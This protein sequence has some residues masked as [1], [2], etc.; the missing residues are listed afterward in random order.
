MLRVVVLSLSLLS[1]VAA[2]DYEG[3]QVLRMTLLSEEQEEA[4]LPLLEDEELDFWKFPTDLMVPP[5]RVK[6]IKEYLYASKIPHNIW[7]ADVQSRID[8]QF[9]GKPR[10]DEFDYSVYHTVDEIYEWVDSMVATYPTLASSESIGMSYEDNDLVVLKMGVNTGK[11]KRNVWFKSLLH[12]REWVSGAACM[13]IANRLMSEYSSNE[14]IQ[15][16]LETYDF[17]YMPVVN[18]DGYNAS[19]H[20][21]RLWRKTRSALNGSSCI[22]VDGNRN[23]DFNWGQSGASPLPCT[24]T[25][26]GPE[27]LSEPETA[28]V[29]EFFRSR[30]DIVFDIFLDYHSYSQM[31]LSPWGY[32]D[33][34]PS[35]FAAMDEAMK[36]STEAIAAVH[37]MTY[38]YGASGP[39]LYTTSGTTVDWAYGDQ[40]IVHSYTYELRDEGQYGF[41]LP[42]DQIIPTAE[43]NY[44]GFVALCMHVANP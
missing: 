33:E 6:S 32:T 25:Y 38:I 36:V 17:Y 43:E 22:G 39:T 26:R 20:G 16:L 41:V 27:A 8:A 24:S 29:A 37:N 1:C 30:P 18:P 21:E 23:F 35:D 11:P 7:I 14:N 40:N 9:S 3:Y 19:W 44:A 4:L 34:L 28:A 42:E 13:Y 5:N 10:T 12:A 2:T 31:M 15:F